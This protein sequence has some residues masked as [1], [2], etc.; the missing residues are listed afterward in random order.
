M[1]FCLFMDKN[2][3]VGIFFFAVGR[4]ARSRGTSLAFWCCLALLSLG[5]VLRGQAQ[6]AFLSDAFWTYQQDCNGDTY[7]AGTLPGNFARLNWDPEV[8]NCNGTLTVFEKV[9]SKPCAASTWTS[10]YTNSPHTIVACRSS[11]QQHLDVLMGGGSTCRDYKIEIYR[12]GQSAP[13]YVR[14]STNDVDLAQ[15]HEQLLSEDFC[16]SDFFASCASPSGV[17]GSESD[18]NPNATKEPGEPNHAGNSGGKSLWY[19]WTATTNKP[20]TF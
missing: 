14:S 5:C 1:G 4:Q 12:N 15:H 18:N 17:S 19:C 6:T 11:G 3:S 9:Y 8:T 13:D 16:L 7:K 20:V 10:I 2:N